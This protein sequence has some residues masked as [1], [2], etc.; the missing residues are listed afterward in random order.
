MI[1]EARGTAGA[2]TARRALALVEL[3]A[4]AGAALDLSA[5][6]DRSGLSRPTAYRLLRVLGEEG[7]LARTGRSGWSTGVRLQRLGRQ[8]AQGPDPAQAVAPVLATVAA[9]T[10]ETACLHLIDGREVVLI[11][12]S[13]S[14]HVLRRSVRVGERTPLFRGAAGTAALAFAAIDVKERVLR[15]LDSSTREEVERRLD[16]I[17]AS[18]W[19][20][21]IGENHAGIA[22]IAAPVTA[23]STG[24][25]VGSISVAGPADRFTESA[26]AAAVDLLLDQAGRATEALS[27]ISYG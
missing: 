10:G 20:Q 19:S 11:A 5:V 26:R 17:K 14:G 18:G 25:T 27:T 24:P 15:P 3:I 23:G 21:S 12:G 7:W 16:T 6:V 13:E 2:E 9:A 22:G 1:D 8:L 4:D